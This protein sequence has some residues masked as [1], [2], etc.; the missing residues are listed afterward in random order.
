[1]AELSA[2]ALS[3]LSEGTAGDAAVIAMAKRLGMHH[4]RAVSRK[5][6]ESALGLAQQVF[7]CQ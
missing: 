6:I 2:L 3:V 7:G 1:M 5:R 4:V